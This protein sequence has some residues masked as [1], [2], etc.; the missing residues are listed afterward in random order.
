LD[1]ILEN[2]DRSTGLP[3]LYV[4]LELC[5]VISTHKIIKSLVLLWCFPHKNHRRFDL[6][7]P[8]DQAG[9]PSLTQPSVKALKENVQNKFKFSS[10]R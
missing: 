1:K 2:K 4:F 10:I 5:P 3:D 9:Y 7:F 8:A 6:R